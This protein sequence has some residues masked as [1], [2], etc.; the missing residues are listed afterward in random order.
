[1]S[2]IAYPPVWNASRYTPLN[3]AVITAKR[4]RI[5][6]CIERAQMALD[7]FNLQGLKTFRMRGMPQ[8]ARDIVKKVAEERSVSIMLLASSSRMQKAVQARN[9]A[10]YLIKASKPHLSMSHFAK[11]FARN[12]TSAMH[13]IASHADKHNLPELVGYDFQR[14]RQRN[15]RIS[16]RRRALAN[17]ADKP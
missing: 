16:E 9:E 6:S 12:H 5:I 11:W 4:K 8:T 3:K 7:E 13:G 14:V 2:L 15:A 10:M 1:M 17:G